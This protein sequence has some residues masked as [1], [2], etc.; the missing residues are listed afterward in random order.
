LGLLSA[1]EEIGADIADLFNYLTGF[2][3]PAHFRKLLVAP[4]TL[5]QRLV[6]EIRSV[7]DAAREG[8]RA[9]IRLKVNGLTHVEIID[10]LYA[11][12]EAGA[13]IEPVV[14]GVCTLRPGVPGLSDGIRVRSVLGRFLEHSRVFH[15]EAGDAS[16][17]YFGSADLMP[18][19]LDHRVEVVAPIEDVGAQNELAATID[20]LLA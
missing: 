18:R 4:F 5:R 6:E 13:R 15:F 16:R 9:R 1:D 7:A 19:N 2:G 8:R 20:S 12:S 14:R 3:R 10:E 11:A 17:F